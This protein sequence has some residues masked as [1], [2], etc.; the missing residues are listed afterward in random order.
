MTK[1]KQHIAYSKGERFTKEI[2]NLDKNKILI[3]PI[4]VA[5]DTHKALVAN[6][7]GDILLQ[8]FSFSNNKLG[9][10]LF[11]TSV[12][13]VAKEIQAQK[14]LVGLEPTGS[15][16]ENLYFSLLAM[17]YNVLQV[18]PYSVSLERKK[19]LTWCKTDERDLCAIGQVLINNC[20]TETRLH[21]G[22]WYNFKQLAR[23]YRAEVRRKATLKNQIRS[24]MDRIF[25][26]L[27]NKDIFSDFFCPASLLLMENYPLPTQI[28][29]LG[30]KRLKNFFLKHN[31]RP[32]LLTL[33]SLF[34]AARN[35]IMLSE[36]DLQIHLLNLRIRLQDFK[37]VNENI[38]LFAVKMAEFLVRTPGILLLSIKYINVPSAS[39]YTAEMGPITDF[40][41]ARQ[42]IKKA[43]TNPGRYQTGKFDATNLSITKQGMG[44]F[45]NIVMLISN[46]LTQ[47]NYFKNWYDN[48]TAK[49]KDKDLA[50]VALGNKF[51][52]ISF[53]MMCSGSLF[54]PPGWQGESDDPIEKLEEFLIENNAQH[55]KD[56]LSAIAETQIKV[57]KRTTLHGKPA[58]EDKQNFDD[59]QQGKTGGDSVCTPWG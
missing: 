15:Y 20:A 12:M 30:E 48:F 5:K 19:D 42:V 40:R 10:D 28:I 8:P 2:R 21:S 35:A 11:N 27:Q 23:L 59:K 4:E 53:S 26:G 16:Y 56:K 7:Y 44:S 32:S 3:I 6:Y 24:C 43:G 39:E 1:C 36:E 45:R 9:V 31:I 33:E 37:K 55:L 46:N 34:S 25:P 50:R 41:H 58:V 22:L 47:N 49:G 29:S 38:R 57:K 52:R 13:Q 18:N 51:I 54:N 17:G 14:I